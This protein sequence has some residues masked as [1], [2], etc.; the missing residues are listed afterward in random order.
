MDQIVNESNINK[1]FLENLSPVDFDSTVDKL[2]KLIEE[3]SWKISNIYDLQMTLN[4]HG[5]EVL[6]VKVLSLCHPAHSGRILEKNDERIITPMMPCRVSVYKK[7]DGKTYISRMNSLAF[8]AG[9]DGLIK[10]VMTDSANE[11]EEIITELLQV[12]E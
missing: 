10:Q 1:M 8:A 4:K 9:F 7:D 3:K 11:V 5:K 6:P 2:S 12:A